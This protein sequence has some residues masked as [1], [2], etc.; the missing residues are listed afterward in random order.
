MLRMLY[1]I[2]STYL[3][4]CFFCEKKEAL[5]GLIGG[6]VLARVTPPGRMTCTQ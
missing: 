3:Q 1:P 4:T 2:F 5:V 6:H